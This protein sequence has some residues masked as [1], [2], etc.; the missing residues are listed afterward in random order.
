MKTKKPKRDP[1][2]ERS[3]EIF[4]NANLQDIMPKS[5]ATHMLERMKRRE[6]FESAGIDIDDFHSPNDP[7]FDKMNNANLN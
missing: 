4:M 1:A 2:F 7:I 5:L 3:K 6:A